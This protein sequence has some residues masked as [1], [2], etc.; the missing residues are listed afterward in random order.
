MFD[1]QR[2]AEYLLES[3]IVKTDFALSMV[4]FILSTLRY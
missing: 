3:G 2:A 4:R 1:T